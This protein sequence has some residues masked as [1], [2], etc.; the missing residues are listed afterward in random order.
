[1]RILVYGGRD[2]GY[3]YENN[4]KKKDLDLIN[5]SV[6]FVKSYK[7]TVIICGCALG[8]DEIGE[9]VSKAMRIPICYFPA[10]W[11]KFGK[12]AGF[13]RN[14]QMLDE[15]KP[16]LGIGFPGGNGTADMTRRILKAGVNNVV[17]Y[18]KE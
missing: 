14:Q 1:M 13:I 5:K 9:Y 15:G 8:G 3:Y 4:I 16:D 11:D 12:G 7:P 17:A 2:Y 6:D 10:N 18:L